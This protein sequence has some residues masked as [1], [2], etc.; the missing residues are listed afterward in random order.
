MLRPSLRA[1]LGAS[2]LALK[3][4]YQT[5]CAATLGEAELRSWAAY[6]RGFQR[7][8]PPR[9]AGWFE[10]QEL[11]GAAD[12]ALGRFRRDLAARRAETRQACAA[13]HA[14]GSRPRFAVR[15]LPRSPAA[16]LRYLRSLP[17]E[18]NPWGA[19]SHAAH[20]V[21]FLKLNAESFGRRSDFSALLPVVLDY[22]D[23]LQDQATGSWF[24][25]DP[26]TEQKVN[27]AMKVLTIY[28]M[29]DRPLRYADRLVDLCLGAANEEDACHN[30]DVLYVLHECSR[31]TDHRAAEVRAFAARRLLGLQQHVKPDGAFSFLPDRAGEY[32]YGVR[33]SRGLAES[34]VHG[35]HLLVWAATLIGDLLGFREELG[36]KLPV[37]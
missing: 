24:R 31:W 4:S 11:L 1:G 22:L 19:G 32:Y 12:R 17:W 26:A 8:R 28:E 34:D 21:F 14:V 6:V 33:V 9:F 30:V 23:G 37:T 7:R 18:S 2:A 16:V 35:T 3:V 15:E 25:G 36:W 20:L 5:G 27:A 10:D 13:L 29:L